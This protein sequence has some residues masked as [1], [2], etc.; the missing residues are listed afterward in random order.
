MNNTIP[1]DN[2][3]TATDSPQNAADSLQNKEQDKQQD[4]E[5]MPS[6]ADMWP[7]LGQ[8]RFGRMNWV[9]LWT[10]YIKEVRRF[11]KVGVQ[12]V[13]APVITTMLFLMIFSLALGRVRPDING[14]PF[15]SFLAPGLII[16][17]MLQ[18]AFANTSSSLVTSKLQGNIIDILMPPLSASELNIGLVFGGVTRGLVVGLFTYFGMLYMADFTYAAPWAIFYFAISACFTLALLGMLTGIWAEKFDHMQAITNFIIMPLSFLSGTFYSVQQ[19]P[20]FMKIITIFNPFFYMI[21]GFR[22]GFTG[23][24]E[25][26]I[27]LGAVALFVLNLSLWCI[28]QYMLIKGYKIKN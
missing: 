7:A 20:E 27:V 3:K 2:E 26:N 18:N 13:A 25:S 5:A 9:G 15:T 8:R 12:T 17:A 11:W 1:P 22:Y 23:Q 16:M 14:V 6:I 21:D 4:K 10:L 19:L 28:S 24:S